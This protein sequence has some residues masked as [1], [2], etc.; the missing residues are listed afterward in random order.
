MSQGGRALG[1]QI[2]NYCQN[3]G[4]GSVKCGL[5]DAFGFVMVIF[6]IVVISGIALLLLYLFF[7]KTITSIKDKTLNKF[8]KKYF[9]WAKTKSNFKFSIIIPSIFAL[10]FC[11]GNPIGISFNLFIF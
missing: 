2:N 11:I 8:L 10:L 7:E 1:Q 4:A 9:I 6:C 5:M 3:G